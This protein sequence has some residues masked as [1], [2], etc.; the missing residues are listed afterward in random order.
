MWGLAL[1]GR[2]LDMK[3]NICWTLGR[4]FRKEADRLTRDRVLGG[5]KVSHRGQGRADGKNSISNVV[6]ENFLV[7]GALK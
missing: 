1:K 2:L 3:T 4:E 6:T 7:V 5:D